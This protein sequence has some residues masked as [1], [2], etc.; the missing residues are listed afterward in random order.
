MNKLDKVQSE[1]FN[2]A[3]EAPYIKTYLQKYILLKISSGDWKSGEWLPSENELSKR[4][5]CS[6]LTSRSAL[7]SLVYSGVLEAVH[8]KG[9]IVS[10]LIEKTLFSSTGVTYQKTHSTVKILDNWKEVLSE[11]WLDS[12]EHKDNFLSETHKFEK[13]YY[14]GNEKLVHQFSFVNKNEVFE[15]DIAKINDSFVKYMT[16]YGIV[17]TSTVEKILFDNTFP[18]LNNIAKEMGWANDF[19]IMLNIIKTSNNWIEISV[20]IINKKH[21]NFV[22]ARRVII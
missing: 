8:G 12:F 20:K 4:F 3:I 19:P 11:D 6:R 15:L 14:N 13:I 7:Q 1:K 5:E 18:K 21:F 10:P 16:W 2:P 9:Y 17:I 22:R